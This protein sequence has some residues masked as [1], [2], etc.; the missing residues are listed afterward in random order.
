MEQF[1][2]R[3]PISVTHNGN[4]NRH[5]GERSFFIRNLKDETFYDPERYDRFQIRHELGI[6]PDDKIILFG[7][8]LR[9]HKGIFELLNFIRKSRSIYR[10]LFV[11]SRTTLDQ[12]QLIREAEGN[13]IVLS[14]KGRNEMAKINYAA[15]AVVVWLDE[16]IAASHF[17]MPYKLTDAFAMKV[18]VIANDVSDMSIL[19][20]QGYLR[21]VPYGDFEKLDSVLN[22]IFSNVA[23]TREM[24]E[25]A[26]RLYHRQFSYSAAISNME[27]IYREATK[28]DF[29]TVAND[30][31]EFFSKFVENNTKMEASLSF[32]K[33]S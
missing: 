29:S 21:L 25:R 5:F 18:P 10:L 8:M 20:N 19:G 1:A 15:D 14:P 24:V 22:E 4:L 28:Y 11:G 6:E 26:R 32:K 12:E 17:Q 2:Q 9:K 3:T 30:F 27:L 16:N 31:V 7:G 23:E 13:V 33:R